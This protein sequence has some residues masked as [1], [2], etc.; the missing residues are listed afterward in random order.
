MLLLF[1]L[2]C[3]RLPVGRLPVPFAWFCD[4]GSLNVAYEN[5]NVLCVVCVVLL[6]FSERVGFRYRKSLF[7]SSLR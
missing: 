6:I 7:G 1:C 2:T 5:K 4:S 3:N